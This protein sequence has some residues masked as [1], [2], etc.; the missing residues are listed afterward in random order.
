M[1]VKPSK[2]SSA[3][4]SAGDD[5]TGWESLPDYAGLLL[6]FHEAYAGQLRALVDDIPLRPGE[7]VLDVACGDGAFARWFAERA[8]Q[9]RVSAIDLDPAWL[10]VAQRRA[11]RAGLAIDW[12]QGDVERIPW[13]ENTFD[14][15]W[16]AQ[17]LYSL[18]S[19]KAAL[20]EMVRVVRPG[21]IVAILENDT[22]HHILLPWPVEL[23]LKVRE[24][25]LAAFRKESRNAAKYYIGR[26]LIETLSRNGL[27]HV[28]ENARVT[29]RQP[30][31][32]QHELVFW[33]EYLRNLRE[34]VA[35]F[36]AE[37]TSRQLEILASP[38]SDQYLLHRPDISVVC[39]DR[40]VWGVKPGLINA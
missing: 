3:S 17:S 26:R 6:A 39:L 33:T 29:S 38:E 20:A 2:V 19:T 22:L 36:L 16:C 5:E 40:L 4:I 37:S 28:V 25:E 12:V 11:S 10:A 18:P 8:E 7:R 14:V 9:P 1:P 35:P 27:T 31:F 13:S 24:A 32:S 23:E 15:A 34:R 30:P 21:G